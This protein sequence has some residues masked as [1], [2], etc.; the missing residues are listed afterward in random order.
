MKRWQKFW[1]G[2]FP[3]VIWIKSKRTATFFR[4]TFPKFSSVPI[5]APP[6]KVDPAPENT[7]VHKQFFSPLL[8]QKCAVAMYLFYPW[9]FIC[10][11]SYGW[12]VSVY[13]CCLLC[14]L[15]KNLASVKVRFQKA[16]FTV[17]PSV[18]ACTMSMSMHPGGVWS[19]CE[20][21]NSVIANSWSKSV[22][23]TLI[24]S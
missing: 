20:I 23:W 9:D 22:Q 13:S 18:H 12:M 2:P 10:H 11:M 7:K 4:E 6:C 14:D 3:P 24:V 5:W 19:G 1:Q 21:R 8:L 17:C 15:N 16:D